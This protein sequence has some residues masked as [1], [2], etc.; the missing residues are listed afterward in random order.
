M[1]TMRTLLGAASVMA[2][3]SG[4]GGESPCEQIKSS[5]TDSVK[6][7]STCSPDIPEPSQEELDEVFDLEAC[8]RGVEAECTD[9]QAERVAEFMTCAM[10]KLTCENFQDQEEYQEEVMKCTEDGTPNLDCFRA[11]TNQEE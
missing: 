4:C 8:E 9:K 7:I 10:D 6:R 3:L 5:L 2:L 1:K 11:M